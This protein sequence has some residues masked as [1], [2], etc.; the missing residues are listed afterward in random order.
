M[1]TKIYDAYK[2]NG[3]LY[4]LFNDLKDIREKYQ[5]DAIELLSKCR[6]TRNRCGC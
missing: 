4:S 3:N 2:Y 5:E 1:S 6:N